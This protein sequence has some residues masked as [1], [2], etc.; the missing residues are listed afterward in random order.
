MSQRDLK[1]QK[2]QKILTQG[3]LD[4]VKDS[5][6]ITEEN[7]LKIE[8][9]VQK[10]NYINYI[11]LFKIEDNSQ[12]QKAIEKDSTLN[13]NGTYRYPFN[14]KMAQIIYPNDA[15]QLTSP[16]NSCSNQ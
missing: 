11:A 8:E 4:I 15:Q 14:I 7:K 10:Y 9:I 12:I 13:I 16:L 6:T 1:F 2:E 5:D 3:I